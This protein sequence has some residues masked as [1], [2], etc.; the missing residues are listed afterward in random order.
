MNRFVAR[1]RLDGLDDLLGRRCTGELLVG[2]RFRFGKSIRWQRAFG[3]RCGLGLSGFRRVVARRRSVVRRGIGQTTGPWQWSHFGSLSNI[4]REMV[5]LQKSRQ[6]PAREQKCAEIE[7]RLTGGFGRIDAPFVPMDN[8]FTELLPR[9]FKFLFAVCPVS[10]SSFSSAPETE[11]QKP[12]GSTKARA[13]FRVQRLSTVLC[14]SE[15]APLQN[16]PK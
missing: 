16:C 5:K 15:T 8:V 3:F 4:C 13:G 9:F 6:C 7:S 11:C 2:R 10:D 12:F 1:R 14:A